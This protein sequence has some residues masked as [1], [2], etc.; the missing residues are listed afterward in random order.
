MENLVTKMDYADE[1]AIKIFLHDL[2]H[3]L[4]DIYH[5]HFFSLND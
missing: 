1:A 5:T 2:E 4:T 3:F